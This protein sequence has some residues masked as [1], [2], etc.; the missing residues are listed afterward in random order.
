M[1]F[2]GWTGIGGDC[3]ARRLAF[4]LVCDIFAPLGAPIAEPNLNFVVGEAGAEANVF[5]ATRVR[6]MSLSEDRLELIDLFGGEAG[7]QA[8][9][10]RQADH[11]RQV[12]IHEELIAL[13][14]LVLVVD[15]V[16]IGVALG[17]GQLFARLGRVVQLFVVV[18]FV[19][20]SSDHNF[21]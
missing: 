6:I 14:Q 3:D 10:L 7:A 16:V 15:H 9:V 13:A 12:L 1:I 21:F 2:V 4:G 11:A 17:C 19:Q 18:G 5:A 20:T 8:S